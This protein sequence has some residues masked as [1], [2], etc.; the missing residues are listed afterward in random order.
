VSGSSDIPDE[1]LALVGEIV[2]PFGVRGQLKMR[3]LMDDPKALTKLPSVRLHFPNGSIER[4]RVTAVQFHQGQALVTLEGVD[5]R[6]QSEGLRGVQVYI[7]REELPKPEP[8]TYYDWQLVG[9]RV[10]TDAGKDLGRIEKVLFYPA[11]D[12]YETEVALIPAVD[13]FVLQVDLEAGVLRV[14]DVPGLR[15][16]E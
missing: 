3:S 5:D 15:K 11:N 9:L 4:R 12:V 1:S 2:A 6:N 8:D 16:D 10:E 14:R 13:E 7:G